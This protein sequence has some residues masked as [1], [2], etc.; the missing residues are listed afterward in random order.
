[1][2]SL[3]GEDFLITNYVHNILLNSVNLY[4]NSHKFSPSFSL[5]PS[6]NYTTL[7][8]AYQEIINDN[9]ISIVQISQT[10]GFRFFFYKMNRDIYKIITNLDLS[11]VYEVSRY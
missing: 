1:M 10:S 11:I 3:F 7:D 9:N 5:L 4:L 6:L 2:S 8:I